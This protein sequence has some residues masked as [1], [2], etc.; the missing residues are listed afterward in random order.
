MNDP[1]IPTG[2]YQVAVTCPDCG[3]HEQLPARLG[4]RLTVPDDDDPT[5]R[6]VLK[7]KPA[8]H[9]CRQTRIDDHIGELR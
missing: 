4:V 1:A 5:L 3:R 2:T 8:P 6:V 7:T 9:V